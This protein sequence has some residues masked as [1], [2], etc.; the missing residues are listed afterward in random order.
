MSDWR[1]LPRKP[2]PDLA[3][4]NRQR[5]THGLSGSP[6]R[7]SWEAM[8][9]RCLVERDKDYP[10]YGGRG[11]TVCD[12]WRDS[13]VAF[14]EDMG[15]K[16]E[17]TS[18]DRIDNDGNYDPDNCRWAPVDVQNNNRRSNRPLTHQGRTQTLAQWAR[19]TGMSRA[20]LANRIRNGWPLGDALSTPVDYSNRRA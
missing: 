20:T 15:V 6:T 13:F 19:E 18:L 16:P 3:E 9:R 14:V 11:I 1:S 2:R 4:R 5:A 7:K 8:K 10:R 17:G 12:R